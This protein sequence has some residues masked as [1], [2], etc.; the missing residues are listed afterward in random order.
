MKKNHSEKK[1]QSPR[2]QKQQKRSEMKPHNLGLW[3]EK[4]FSSHASSFSFNEFE[5]NYG[6]MPGSRSGLSRQYAPE[7]DMEN[8]VNENYSLSGY[9]GKGPKNFR[10][11]DETILNDIC[12][13]LYSSDEIDASNI[14]VTVESGVTTLSGTVPIHNMRHHAEDLVASVFGVIRVLNVLETELRETSAS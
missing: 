13:K 5:D 4:E 3:N 1:Q 7:S 12:E 8:L 11:K 6:N 10:R 9:W 14:E 2:E